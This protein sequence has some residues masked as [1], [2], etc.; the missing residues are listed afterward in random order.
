MSN[1]QHPD[2][3][4]EFFGDQWSALAEHVKENYSVDHFTL[5]DN[6]LVPSYFELLFV[7][8]NEEVGA[9]IMND[10]FV[11]D[12]ATSIEALMAPDVISESGVMPEVHVRVRIDV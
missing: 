3:G 7:A 6:L 10:Q 9:K 1:S 12:T 5:M 4:S 2:R 8:A 11:S